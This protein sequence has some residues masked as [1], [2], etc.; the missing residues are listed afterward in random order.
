MGIVGDQ[1]QIPSSIP[2]QEELTALGALLQTVKLPPAVKM[3]ESAFS[4]G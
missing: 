3:W 1:P 2:G 4:S